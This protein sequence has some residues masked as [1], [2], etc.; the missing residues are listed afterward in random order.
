[1]GMSLSSGIEMVLANCTILVLYLTLNSTSTC[2][3]DGAWAYT[4]RCVK[5][6]AGA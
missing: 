6:P 4:V 5:S 1:M 3:T 2:S